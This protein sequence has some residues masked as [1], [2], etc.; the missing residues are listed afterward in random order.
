MLLVAC[1]LGSCAE[2]PYVWVSELPRSAD[3][4]G[5]I[6]PR[7]V[8]Y[9]LVRN[10]AALSGEFTVRDDG[11]YA[12]PTLGNV[13]VVGKTPADVALELQA[14]L[15]DMIVA[16]EVSV[17]TLKVAPIR[18]DV[19]GE[20]KTPGVYELARDRGVIAAL[21]AAGWLTEFARRD[22]IFVV[23]A[24]EK[25]VRFEAAALTGAEPHAVSFRLHDGDVVV[26]E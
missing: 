5:V 22:R 16:P 24:A 13:F 11:A 23:R 2:H 25:R 18:V 1:L 26:V 7:D 10:Q 21:A 9:V 15:K 4:T 14:R 6:G 12:Q 17:A 19:V 8:I 3:A 20:V